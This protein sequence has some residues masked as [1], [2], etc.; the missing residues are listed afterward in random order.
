MVSL[1]NLVPLKV[2]DLLRVDLLL[3]LEKVH[4]DITLLGARTLTVDG[5]EG[6]A[7]LNQLAWSLIHLS[8]DHYSSGL[9]HEQREAAISLSR[10]VSMIYE[11]S[12]E[13]VRLSN[14]ISRFFAAIRE[15]LADLGSCPSMRW[16]IAIEKLNSLSG[17]G[18]P[19]TYIELENSFTQMRVKPSFALLA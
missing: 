16:Y 17:S 1:S 8:F 4:T 3:D 5:R 2:E 18:Q 9:F 19:I 15:W 10:K 14:C 13:Q 6:V 7:E 11:K 12:D